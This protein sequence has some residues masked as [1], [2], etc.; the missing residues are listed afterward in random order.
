MAHRFDDRPLAVV[1][2]NCWRR[3][4]AHRVAFL[5]DA[6]AY[7]AAFAS[8]VARAE[9]SI[10][11][12]G[13]DV[14]GDI[15][16]RRDGRSE[17]PDRLGD[18][19][20]AVLDRRPGLHANVL[21]WDFAMI[22]ALEREPL[23]LVG[24]AW[25]RHPRL[26]FRLDGSHP[27]GGSHHQKLVV[28]DDAVAFIGGLD[29]AACRWDTPEH[30]TEDPRRVDPGYR[31]YAPFHDVQLAVD[32]PVAA[33]LGDLARSRWYRATGVELAPPPAPASDA[34]P[35]GLR[36]DLTDVPVALARTE[37]AWGGRPGIHEVEQLYLDAVA[38]A[39]RSIYLETQYLTSPRLGDA[40][41]ARLAEADGPD[42][43]MVVPRVCAGWLEETTMGALRAR[44]LRRLRDADLHGRLGVYHPTVPGLSR[45]A[46]VNVHA[47]V[48]V[49][50]DALVRVGSANAS[51]RSMRLDTECDAVIEAD[52]A[53]A[54]RAA[55]AGFRNRLLAEHLGVPA[56]RVADAVAAAPLRAAV[57]R[58]RGGART[59]VSL[60]PPTPQWLEDIV[61]D[62]PLIDPEAPLPRQSMAI[63]LL[64]GELASARRFVVRAFAILLGVLLLA[65]VWRWTSLPHVLAW[66][67]RTVRP[68]RTS[69]ATALAVVTAFVAG[70]LLLVPATGLIVG[71]ALVFGAKL[72]FAY[73]LLGS[74]A[75]AFVAYGLGRALSRG[76][77]RR[78]LGDVAHAVSPRLARRGVRSVATGRLLPIAPFT[79]VNLVAG[80]AGVD[81]RTFALRTVVTLTAGTWLLT[82]LADSFAEAIRRPGPGTLAA[83][84]GVVVLLLLLGPLTRRRPWGLPALAQEDR[85]G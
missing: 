67:A 6:A 45:D 62:T 79:V 23:P 7:Y 25:A 70:G 57:E 46:Q 21:D 15:R 13:W 18:L 11:V 28:I 54:V 49:I 69:P 27:L 20:V 14:H 53:P 44:V 83:L 80:A 10:L 56:E 32:G 42:V 82:L 78:L 2:R 63:E 40:L 61:P 59:L 52:G 47:K 76:R 1:G 30:R 58:L 22:Y 51:N 16:L 65:M 33:T 19:L 34:W 8:A 41:A 66:T 3:A 5:V 75:S 55:I 64:V 39:R 85:R 26:H 50:D 43:V 24:R 38:A 37:P 31:H 4:R 35:P 84:I 74:L 12:V 60:E 81:F 48:L 72:G 29:L 36:P 9:R 68:V 71:A 73:A 17:L 77:V